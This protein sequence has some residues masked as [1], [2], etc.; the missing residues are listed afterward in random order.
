MIDF[1]MARL[2]VNATNKNKRVLVGRRDFGRRNMPWLRA[3]TKQC[4]GPLQA[5]IRRRALTFGGRYAEMAG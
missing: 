3:A 4:F 5:A 2:E 1:A